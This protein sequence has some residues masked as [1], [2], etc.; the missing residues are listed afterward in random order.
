MNKGILLSVFVALFACLFIVSCSKDDD[1]APD[2]DVNFDRQ[3]LLSSVADLIT[4]AY[5]THNANINDLDA[6]VSTFANQPNVTTLNALKTT[7]RQTLLDWQAVAPYEFGEAVN[8]SF[9]ITHNTYPVDASLI[10]DN[11]VNGGYNLDAASNNDAIGLQAMDYLLHANDETTTLQL[12]TADSNAQRRVQYLV[13]L[14]AQLKERSDVL[15][16]VWQAGSSEVSDF[17]SN[18]GTSVGS[19]LGSFLNATIKS[20]EGSTRSNKLG[21]PAGALT[22]S[23]TPLPGHVEAFYENTHSIEYLKASVN[24]FKNIYLGGSGIGLD[25]YLVALNAQHNGIPLNQAI[26]DQFA[27][28]DAD[29]AQLQAP[30]SDLVVNDQQTAL[31]VYA[32]LQELVV[33]FKVDMMSA[34]GV[35]VTYQD[36]DGD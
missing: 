32:E 1:P 9:E 30:L 28:I 22:F 8:Q 18:D 17:I 6:T 26:Q 33:L 27:R 24:A 4:T 19:S 10:L 36:N 5:A 31:D 7:W 14:V 25:D 2:T 34:L 3:A 11:I 13:D 29:L 20:F 35:L 23:M 21:L 12:F 15:T 16:S